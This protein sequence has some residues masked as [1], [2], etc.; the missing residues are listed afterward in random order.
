MSKS[1]IEAL[2]TS[3]PSLTNLRTQHT[4]VETKTVRYVYQPLEELYMVLITTKGSNILQDIDT[5]HLFAQVV[6][7][8]CNNNL[9]ER[10]VLRNA[11]ELISAFDEI[12][13]MGYRETLTLPQI[14]N[15]LEMESQEE[16]IQDI[17]SRVKN[18]SINADGRTR[19][20]KQ[21]KNENV[22]HDNWKCND[23]KWQS[24][25]P[26]KVVDLPPILDP[27]NINQFEHHPLMLQLHL[28]ITTTKLRLPKGIHWRERSDCRSVPAMKGKGMQLGGKTNALLK[29]ALSNEISLAEESAS[30]V[31]VSVPSH[32]SAENSPP[33]ASEGIQISVIETMSA[34]ANRDGNVESLEV[35]GQL[36]LQISDSTIS[37]VQI[38][39]NSDDTDGTQFKS[40]PNVDR[41]L[42]KDQHKI[43]LRDSS[44]PFPLNQQMSVLRWRLQGKADKSLPIS[45]S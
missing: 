11:F 28:T 13:T 32:A 2:L 26:D 37:R 23:V 15:I 8:V 29:N 14:K 31:S 43:G 4:S 9:D 19:N 34:K 24:L 20:K 36:N 25:G 12:I 1:Q 44:R 21:V 30:N 5:L 10:E 22:E 18:I 7:F 40:H 16:K 42:F 27:V 6:T 3:F 39:V 33:V 35:Q 45:G 17:I 38:E 41:N